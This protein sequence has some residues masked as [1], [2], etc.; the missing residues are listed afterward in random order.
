MICLLVLH[1]GRFSDDSLLS[2]V[3]FGIISRPGKNV[4]FKATTKDE[5]NIKQHY[6]NVKFE[7]IIFK[8]DTTNDLQTI[9]VRDYNCL[10][11]IY[12]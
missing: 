4:I 12:F 8:F 1:E 2:L 5:R 7:C 3:K 10:N 9:R 11:E 6:Y